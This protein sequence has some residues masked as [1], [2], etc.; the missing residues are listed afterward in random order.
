MPMCMCMLTPTRFL[1][2]CV[3]TYHSP[4]S[5]PPACGEPD[6][7]GSSTKKKKLDQTL[8]FFARHR[9]LPDLPMVAH[10]AKKFQSKNDKKEDRGKTLNYERENKEIRECLDVSRKTKW[11]KW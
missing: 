5:A 7:G 6:P 8:S 4:N 9:R 11:T 1:S 3:C 2:V 10:Y